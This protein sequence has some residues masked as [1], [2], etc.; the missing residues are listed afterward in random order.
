MLKEIHHRVKNNMQI[1][2]SLLQLQ[3]DKIEDPQVRVL[4]RESES[5][6]RSLALVHEKLYQSENLASIDLGDYIDSLGR[7]LLQTYSNIKVDLQLHIEPLMISLDKAIPCG[8]ILNELITNTLKHAF[9]SGQSGQIDISLKQ[10]GAND[11]C[12]RV[13]DNGKG[14]P[15]GFDW[16]QADTLGMQLIDGLAH[17]IGAKLNVASDGGTVTQLTFALD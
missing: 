6:I 10:C 9:V 11:C 1:I 17:Q 5:R 16:H 14:L 15:A 4:M 8:L 2:S 13:A 7:Y 3:M 12:L